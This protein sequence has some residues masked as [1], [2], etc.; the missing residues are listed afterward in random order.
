MD[1]SVRLSSPSANYGTLDI[2]SCDK[3]IMFPDSEAWAVRADEYA[4]HL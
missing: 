4:N 2:N 3:G 1:V